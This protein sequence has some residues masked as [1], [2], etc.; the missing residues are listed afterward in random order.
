MSSRA[1]SQYVPTGLRTS[2]AAGVS[3]TQGLPL[4]VA[5]LLT[6]HP[7]LVLASRRF[8]SVSRL[9]YL[10]FE[11]LDVGL[12]FRPFSTVQPVERGGQ[13]CNLRLQ[14]LDAGVRYVVLTPVGLR[15]HKSPDLA[16]VLVH[17]RPN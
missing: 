2:P 14:L 16:C 11:E 3:R 17:E 10:T 7:T 15:C 13:L 8:V 4:R 12:D 9:D 6:L 5:L 1:T